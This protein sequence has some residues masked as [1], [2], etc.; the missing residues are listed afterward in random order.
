[1]SPV[2]LC[3]E[4]TCGSPAT[5]RG[6]CDEHRKTLERQRSRSRRKDARERNVFYASKAWRMTRRQQLLDHPFCESEGCDRLAEVVHHRVDLAAGGAPRDPE[7]LA[8]LCKPHHDAITRAR[9]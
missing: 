4:P 9:Q 2:R 5:A 1:M 8:S 6:R 7:N 3:A